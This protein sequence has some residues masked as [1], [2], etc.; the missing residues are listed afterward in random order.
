[1]FLGWLFADRYTAFLMVL[2]DCFTA[3]PR[4][5]AGARLTTIFLL[6]IWFLCVVVVVV[7][8]DELH[9]VQVEF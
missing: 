3:A 5:F 9:T 2:S 4:P 6:G 7:D 8:G 1:M